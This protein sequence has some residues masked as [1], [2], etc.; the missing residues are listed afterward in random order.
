MQEEISFGIWLRKQRRAL[1]LS[2]QAFADQ[3]GCAEVTLRR[4]ETGTLKP[5]KELASIILEKLGIPAGEHPRWISFARGGSGFPESSK[6]SRRPSTN[7]PASLTTFIGREKEQEDVKKLTAKHRL[8]TLTGSGGVGKTRLSIKVG[9]QI[10]E[11][12]DDGVWLV[13][14]AP[15]VDPALVAHTIILTLGIYSDPQRRKLDLLCDALR[16]KKMLLLLDNCEHLLEACGI[17]IDTILKNCPHLK[18]LATSR[19]PLNIGGEALYRVPSLGLPKLQQIL[20]TLRNY[21]SI[22][23]FEERA[24]LIQFDFSLTLENAPFVAQICERLDGIPL[25]IELAAAKVSVFSPEQIAKQLHESFN[26]LAQGSRAAL[27]RHQTLHAS[28]TWSWNLLTEWEKR[29]MRQLS[30][31]AG[32][33]TLE[34]AQSVCDGDVLHLLNA[35]VTKSLVVMNRRPETNV[36][37]S[38]HETIRQYARE[39]LLEAGNAEAVRDKHLTYFVKLVE[40]AEPEL[41]RSNQLLW[42]NTLD[43]E[44]DNFR[45]ALEW[46]LATDV[47]SGLRIACIPWHFWEKRNHLQDLRGWLSRFLER[48]PTSDSLRARGLAVYSQ[49]LQVCGDFVE[50]RTIARK[51]LQLARARSDLQ[52]EALSLL[53]LGGSFLF[54]GHMHKGT[55]FLEQSLALYRA[56]GD[57]VGQAIALSWLARDHTDPESSKTLLLECLQLSRDSGNLWCIADCLLELA[58]RSIFEKDFASPL[59][60]L[61]ESRDL[62]HDLGDRANE[63]LVTEVMGTLAYWQGN[64]Q[65]AITYV[66]QSIV[67][68]GN[69]GVWWSAWSHSRL[70]YI[71]LRQGN[72]IR[73]REAFENSLRQFKKYDSLIGSTVTIEGIAILHMNFGQPERAARLIGWVDAMR[74]KVGNPRPQI[75]QESLERDLAIVHTKL[76]QARFAELSKEGRAMTI[77]QAV[78]LAMEPV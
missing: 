22:Q 38:F 56:L 36:R 8:V 45:S 74:E 10:A 43:N 44:L 42:L 48:Y 9:E 49:C 35:L 57:K 65:K 32:G 37:Y 55:P 39:K 72:M 21:E 47:E 23:L 67:L 12:Y 50:A 16:E 34:A 18:I 52:N 5:S 24:Q 46:A 7:L 51:S 26:L 64:Y 1:D 31:F 29:L 25:A 60:W 19:E 41:H 53:F 2:R 30:V 27:P 62:Y 59:P 28:I 6:S 40:R 78:V 4:I 15:I 17:L 54:Q 66:E 71:F 3:V 77:E 61:E 20:E 63:A 11:D 68:Y 70:G 73:S 76:D 14:L 13:E 75:E 58:L 33:W 69:I